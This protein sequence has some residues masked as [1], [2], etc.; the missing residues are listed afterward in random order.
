MTSHILSRR[1]GT[2]IRPLATAS[3]GQVVRATILQQRYVSNTEL[4]DPGMVMLLSPTTD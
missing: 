2:A 1:L 3:R 4:E